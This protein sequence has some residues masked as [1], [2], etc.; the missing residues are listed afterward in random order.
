[1]S[2][3]ALAGDTPLLVLTAGGELHGLDTPE[4]RELVRRIHA[5][6]SA[7]EGISTEELEQGVVADMRRVIAQVVP[8]LQ[9]R[10][11]RAD[12]A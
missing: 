2:H 12:V 11:G 5:C 6:V 8:V 9:A 7:C 3:S 4:N 1:M 10:I